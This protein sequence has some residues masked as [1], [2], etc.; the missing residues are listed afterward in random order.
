MYLVFVRQIMV[1]LQRHHFFVRLKG[2]CFFSLFTGNLPTYSCDEFS[3][4]IVR[5]LNCNSHSFDCAVVIIGDFNINIFWVKT[6]CLEEIF[7]TLLFS[8]ELRH[9]ITSSAMKVRSSKTE[10]VNIFTNISQNSLQSC[11]IIETSLFDHHAQEATINLRTS[12][13]L[14]QILNNLFL[15]G[16]V[17]YKNIIYPGFSVLFARWVLEYCLY[18]I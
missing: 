1:T 17:L 16:I 5:C 18:F 11:A 3:D 8:F 15:V 12:N 10:I 2:V 14:T 7:Y 6:F 4:C 9:T 13:L